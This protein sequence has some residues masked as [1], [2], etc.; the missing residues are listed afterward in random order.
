MP[1]RA[2]NDFNGDGRSDVF[3]QSL[4]GQ[5][6]EVTDWLGQANGSFS[7]NFA[8]AADHVQFP[9][10]FA[11]VGDFNGDGRDDVLWTGPN[12]LVGNWLGQASGGF[13]SNFANFLGEVGPGWTFRGVGDFNGD[14]RADVLWQGGS[15]VTDWLGQTNGG[16]VSNFENA[17]Y[18]LGSEWFVAGIGDF[19]GDRRDDILWRNS[20]TGQVTDWLGQTNGGFVSNVAHANGVV[21]TDTTWG[22][23]GTGDFNG[24]GRDDVLW[25]RYSD[26][27]VTDWLSQPDG[28]FVSNFANATHH[29]GADWHPA[30]IGDYNGDGRDDILWRNSSTSEVTDWLAQPDGGFVSNFANFVAH[31]DMAWVTLPYYH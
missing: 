12:Y 17:D 28:G 3:W 19:N 11:G 26:G 25:M 6:W 18:Q 27:L 13:S 14:G 10:L 7:T 4:P 1:H 23:V 22:I 9:W 5:D 24:D 30:G 2:R 20:N 29:V 8:N 31:V 21:A 16:F 15:Q